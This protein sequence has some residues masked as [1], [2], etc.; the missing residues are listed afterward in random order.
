[1]KQVKPRC[2]PC[3][4]FN[5]IVYCGSGVASLS[6]TEGDSFQVMLQKISTAIGGGGSLP[7]GNS[8]QI[9]S[10]DADGNAQAQYMNANHWS[11][12]PGGAPTTGIWLAAYLPFNAPAEELGFAEVE[13]SPVIQY[14]P[15][16]GNTIPLRTTD[17]APGRLKASD[18][19]DPN[20]LVTLR[21]LQTYISP[22][23]LLYGN[24]TFA[25]DESENVFII[26][27]SMGTIPSSINL[28]FSDGANL[29]FIQSDRSVDANN[30]TITCTNP[31]AG[32]TM[33][34]YW[35]AFK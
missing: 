7:T 17:G 34:V 3:A 14:D 2:N 1:M 16:K 29:E 25:L 15:S 13:M 9:M 18:A 26:T 11:D 30:I 8:R 20:D 6:I 5:R 23:D 28:T 24:K 4:P 10:F 33:T 35:Q 21:Q 27:H 22:T 12:F 19:T 31:P 32:T